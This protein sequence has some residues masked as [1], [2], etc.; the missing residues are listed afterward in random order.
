[1]GEA[2]DRNSGT[3]MKRILKHLFAA[4]NKSLL[5]SAYSIERI[6]HSEPV[7]SE[8]I[9]YAE[10][11]EVGAKN[12]ENKMERVKAGGDFEW[13]NIL[14][15]NEAVATLFGS[16]KRIVNIGAGTGYLEW[17]ASVDRSLSFHASEFDEEC[18]EWCRQNRSAP[19]VVF[20]SDTM[21][22][23]LSQKEPFDLAISIEVIEHIKDFSEFLY[24]F[25]QLA[26]KSIIT[27]PNKDRTKEDS[28]AVTPRYDHHVREWTASEFYWVL[29][30]FYREVNLFAMKDQYV[31][32]LTPV[33]FSTK[34]S[35]LVAVCEY[36]IYSNS[37]P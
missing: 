15:L 31:P 30:S 10:N 26:T 21:E 11:P 19:N 24:E 36:P 4:V 18:V 9:F 8:G 25:S 17:F 14:A 35:P 5:N 12:L 6:D 33:G 2:N 28:Q 1:M 13:P 29:R 34:L 7:P 16:A 37:K 27:T 23:L 3:I 32:L 22:D 20:T